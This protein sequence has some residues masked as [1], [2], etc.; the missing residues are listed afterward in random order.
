MSMLF[1]I[2]LG[3]AGAYTFIDLLCIPDGTITLNFMQLLAILIL[4]LGGIFTLIFCTY[5]KRELLEKFKG[6]K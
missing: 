3:I 2:M 5:F 6:L 1:W 4:P